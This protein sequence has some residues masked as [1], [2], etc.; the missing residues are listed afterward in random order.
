MN[1][2]DSEKD[3][4]PYDA[5]ASI[6]LCINLIIVLILIQTTYTTAFRYFQTNIKNKEAYLQ[7]HKESL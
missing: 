3:L 5:F 7:P 6:F 2:N 4:S 1:K